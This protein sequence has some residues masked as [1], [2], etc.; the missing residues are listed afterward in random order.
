MRLRE[1][2]ILKLL[3]NIFISYKMQEQISEKEEEIRLLEAK[4]GGVE[5]EI[6]WKKQV[7]P[8]FH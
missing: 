1:S 4:I 3:K 8:V 2:S 6:Q 5:K 7:K